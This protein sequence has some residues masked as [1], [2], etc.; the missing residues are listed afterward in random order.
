MN[1]DR[2]IHMTMHPNRLQHKHFT[3]IAAGD[4]A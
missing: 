2:E 4:P 3:G 1:Y